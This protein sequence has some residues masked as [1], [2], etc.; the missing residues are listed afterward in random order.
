MARDNPEMVV[1]NVTRTAS[2]QGTSLQQRLWVPPSS[3][4]DLDELL[5]L[6]AQGNIREIRHRVL[7]GFPG[8]ARTGPGNAS[9]GVVTDLRDI[10]VGSGD[11]EAICMSKA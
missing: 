3:R 10:L 6:A 5:Q 4:E 2:P 11:L 8:T 7:F 9:C 1:E